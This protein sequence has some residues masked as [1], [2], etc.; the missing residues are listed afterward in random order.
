MKLIDERGRLLGKVSLLDLGALLIILV[1]MAG[2]LF[3]PG[4]Q[5]SSVVQV[6]GGESF[7]VEVDMIVRG[8]S[9]RSLDPFKTGEKANLIIRNQA[10]G[11]V[12]VIQI[13]DVSRKIPLVFPDG[14][15]QSVPDPEAY[16]L[17]LVITMAGN[18]QQTKDGLVLGNNKIKIGTPL[19]LE[20]LTYNLR[21]TIMDIR[22]VT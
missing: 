6:G 13:E 3:F 12:D 4:K 1:A 17:D 10:Y 2:V 19:E 21:G 11:Q 18:A 15:V 5:A 22:R 16:R 20:T 8:I 7:P 9:S 14:S